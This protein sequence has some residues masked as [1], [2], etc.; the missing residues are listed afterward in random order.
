MWHCQA[1][2]INEQLFGAADAETNFAPDAPFEK[3]KELPVEL[4]FGIAENGAL[5]ASH[6]SLYVPKVEASTGMG[7][8]PAKMSMA[9]R[10]EKSR[11]FIAT[12]VNEVEQVRCRFASRNIPCLILSSLVVVVFCVDAITSEM[13]C[14]SQ[15]E[16]Q[17]SQR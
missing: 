16:S 4:L 7:D 2:W 15:L 1:L 13:K 6:K 12:D 5:N 11:D 3:S 14:H 17:Q 8:D 9:D 10:I